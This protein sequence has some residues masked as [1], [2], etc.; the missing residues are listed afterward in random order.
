[1]LVS[2]IGVVHKRDLAVGGD[3]EGETQEAQIVPLLLA[4]ASLRKG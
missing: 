4:V 3:E 1:M 2:R